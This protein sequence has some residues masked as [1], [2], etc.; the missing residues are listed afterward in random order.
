MSPLFKLALVMLLSTGLEVIF[1]L[2]PVIFMFSH[3]YPGEYSGFMILPEKVLDIQQSL[4]PNHSLKVVLKSCW[5]FLC[6]IY[7]KG[8]FFYFFGYS[9][10]FGLWHHLSA[11]VL[12]YFSTLLKS[13]QYKLLIPLLVHMKVYENE[14]RFISF[15]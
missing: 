11:S 3:E 5:I 8:Y 13:I 15:A 10:W 14:F 12:F 2:A 7:L 4:V 9:T 1:S 6:P